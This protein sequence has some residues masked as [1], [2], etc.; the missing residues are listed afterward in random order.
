MCTLSHVDNILTERQLVNSLQRV[1]SYSNAFT[2]TNFAIMITKPFHTGSIQFFKT[3]YINIYINVILPSIAC[4]P[5]QLTPL[6]LS[7]HNYVCT[8]HFQELQSAQLLLWLKS[9]VHLWNTT[10]TCYQVCLHLCTSDKHAADGMT[11][12]YWLHLS[13][14]RQQSADSPA[15]CS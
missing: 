5:L 7:N 11:Q 9:T 8:F 12:N 6:R 1:D 3:H 14:E 13:Q 4:V 15:L 2:E 10:L